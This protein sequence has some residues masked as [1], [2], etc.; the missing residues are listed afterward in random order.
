MK[1]SIQFTI[2]IAL[3]VGG[4]KNLAAQSD[5]YAIDS[6][7]EIRIYFSVPNW[8]EALDNLYIAHE[9]GRLLADVEVNGTMFYGAGIRYK[10]FSSYSS[11]RIKNPFNIALDYTYS[12]QAYQGHNKIKLSNVIQDPSFVREVLSYEIAR[13]YMPASRAN[14]ANVYVNDTLRGVYTNVE[15]V[16]KDFLELHYGIRITPFFKGNPESLDLNG[17]NAN[18]SDSPG[19]DIAN[20]FPLYSL[21][22]DDENDWTQLVTFIDT[23]N[24]SPS[25]IS[26]QLNI[27]RTL[28]MHALNYSV[29]NFDS[30]VGYAQ[31]YYLVKDIAGKFNPVLWDMNMS[32]ASYRLTDASDNWD[33]FTINEAKTIDPLQH[34]NSVSVQ[35][36]PLIRNLLSNDTQKRMYLAHMRT[37][38]EENFAN[39]DYFVRAQGFQATIQDDVIADTNKFYSNGAFSTNLTSTVSDLVDYPGIT[40][41]M[42]A[43]T[44]YLMSQPGFSGAPTISNL[45]TN[46]VSTVA[47]DDVWINAE[48]L[49]ASLNVFLSYRFSE[50]E[51]FQTLVMF[52]DG[53][54]SDGSAGD[55]IYGAQIPDIANVIQYYIYAENDSA[56]RFSP[57]RAAYEFHEIVSNVAFKDLAINEVMAK[58][59]FTHAD[60]N[61]EFDDWI[62]LFNNTNY[63]IST[64]GMYLSDDAS[65]PTKWAMPNVVIEPGKYTIIWADGDITQSG[66]HANFS[67]NSLG[68]SLWLSYA[69]GTVIDSVYFGEQYSVVSYGRYPN[70]VGAFQELYPTFKDK[71][72]LS[73]E[74]IVSEVMFIFPNPARNVVNIKLNQKDASEIRI[75][76]MDGR[77]MHA[78]NSTNGEGMITLDVSEFSD[79][80]YHI[81][82]TSETLEI[83]KKL[84]IANN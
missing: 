80:V 48:V 43:R 31:N 67:I 83:T 82:L 34:F 44:T 56:G 60:Q 61:G 17:E 63:K 50:S 66:Y 20:Y 52:D 76:S 84:I 77:L 46:P 78:P 2:L 5:F 41:L 27:D 14:Y 18:L 8:D 9:G 15:A 13:K 39:N 11:T 81:Q 47:G 37:I 53:T 21:K 71:N 55:N 6:V 58:N 35:P 33:G 28:W 69:D 68:D 10:G 16:N 79:G 40:E 51:S 7:Q 72:A 57:E 62:E 23:L 3:F 42:D 24:Q 70:G 54:H 19:T 26:E 65:N 22:S 32:F 73:N 49:E 25:N 38:V 45:T 1:N 30:Y 4:F 36:R 64:A 74:A 29:I 12:D 75:Y 59:S